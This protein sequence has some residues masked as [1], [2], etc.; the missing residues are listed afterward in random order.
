[1]RAVLVML[2]SAAAYFVTAKIGLLLT[3]P[4]GFVSPLWP[5]AGVAVL[6]VLR[7]GYASLPGIAAGSLLSNITAGADGSA[8]MLW[9]EPGTPYLPLFAIGLGAALQAG[10]GVWLARRIASRCPPGPFGLWPMLRILFR[11]GPLACLINSLVALFMLPGFAIQPPEQQVADAIV[12][13][14]G[15]TL[16]V[17]GLMPVGLLWLRTPSGESPP[18]MSTARAPVLITLVLALLSW[19]ATINLG[20]A[21]ASAL[22]TRKE[23]EINYL[24]HHIQ[25][26]LDENQ[27]MLKSFQAFYE[28]SQWVTAA[29]FQ[30]FAKPWLQPNG[31]ITGL[32]WAPRVL[33]SERA[34][35]EQHAPGYDAPLPI[36]EMGPDGH[37]VAAGQRDE[38]WPLTLLTPLD[39][40]K[41]RGFDLM[42]EPVRREAVLRALQTDGPV[43]SRAIRL[44]H[45][46]DD[47]SNTAVVL[48]TQIHGVRPPAVLG[49]AIRLDRLFEE[50]LGDFNRARRHTAATG[51][52]RRVAV[53]GSPTA[54]GRRSAQ[55]GRLVAG[56]RHAPGVRRHSRARLDQRRLAPR[57]HPAVAGRVFAAPAPQ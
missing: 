23:A 19:A 52:R 38:Y 5:A 34:D 49:A 40:T 2:F 42:S 33:A 57:A 4:A 17:L 37:P 24:A 44:M 43:A 12:W 56:P 14:L 25:A 55:P 47:G 35:F 31:V 48:F 20:R 9:P 53:R 41:A 30:R 45:D 11:V 28:S 10:L 13:W 29:E 22:Q 26:H 50:A 36:V 54:S 16:G 8:V 15:D 32:G 51:C 46:A 18:L 27:L 6:L 39:F 21:Q 1:M 3:L 7:L